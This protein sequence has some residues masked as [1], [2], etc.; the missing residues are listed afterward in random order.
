MFQNIAVVTTK[1]SCSFY[2]RTGTYCD[3]YRTTGS[4]QYI[5]HNAGKQNHPGSTISQTSSN[6]YYK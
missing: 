5:D 1:H 4:D 3:C 2:S 6:K